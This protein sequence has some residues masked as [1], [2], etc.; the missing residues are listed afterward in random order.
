M[1]RVS[2]SWRNTIGSAAIAIILAFCNSNTDLKDSDDNRKEF[3]EYFLENLRFLY[4][5]PDGDD[6]KVSTPFCSIVGVYSY[7]YTPQKYKG[8]F[9][10][11]FVLQTFAA[12]LTAFE[13]ACRINGLTTLTS[14][15]HD[16]QEV[17]LSQQLR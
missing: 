3:A 2:D 7:Y 13:G 5:K 12:S 11:P 14:Q 16:Q 9:R 1:Q 6:P 15:L 8:A 4:K 17:S 10:G